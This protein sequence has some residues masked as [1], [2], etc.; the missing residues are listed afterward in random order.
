MIKLV[1]FSLVINLGYHN[2]CYTANNRQNQEIDLTFLES[3]IPGKKL[4]N[5]I[6]ANWKS[7]RA[8][9]KISKFKTELLT[10]SYLT[11][12]TNFHL[13]LELNPEQI[14]QAIHI[15]FPNNLWHDEL[16]KQIYKKWP[17]EKINYQNK[18]NH[19]LFTWTD[20][21]VDYWYEASCVKICFP[22]LLFARQQSDS[23]F[24]LST[25]FLY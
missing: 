18:K 22:I 9:Q 14:I 15:R 8:K 4:P 1:F 13:L 11:N 20:Q 19:G 17:K 16:L 2:K 23:K 25:L 12:N 24:Y 7:L 21:Q 10:Y 3:I 6:G 5:L